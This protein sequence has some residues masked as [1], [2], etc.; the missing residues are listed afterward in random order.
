VSVIDG[1]TRTVTAIVPV[2][3]GAGWV[4]MDPGTHTAYVITGGT[5]WVI[6][7]Q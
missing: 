5:V 2:N 6:E 1:S 4:A 7:H 3:R